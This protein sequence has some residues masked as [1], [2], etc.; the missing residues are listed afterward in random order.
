[1]GSIHHLTSYTPN[2][3]QTAAAL[4]LLLKPTLKNKPINWI[5]EHNTS[6]E[7]MKRLVS[8]I[9]QNKLFNQHLETRIVT[10]ASISRLGASLE[11][12]S[13]KGW[14]EIA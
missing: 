5:P 13:S 9:T 6:F 2:L 11:Q 4:R 7:N 1:M 8:E 10:D 14:V 12:Y 3:A